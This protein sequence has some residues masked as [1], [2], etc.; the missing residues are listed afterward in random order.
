M[1]ITKFELA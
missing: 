1:V